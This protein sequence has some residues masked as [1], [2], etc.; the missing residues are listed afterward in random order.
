MAERVNAIDGWVHQ[1]FLVPKVDSQ[2]LMGK[3]IHDACAASETCAELDEV[4]GRHAVQTYVTPVTVYGLWRRCSP[5]YEPM[6][7]GDRSD[8][9]I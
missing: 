1:T 9:A 2:I 3:R 5:A 7:R 8:L 4:R 6:T